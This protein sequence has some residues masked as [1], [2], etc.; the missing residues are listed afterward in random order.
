MSNVIIS[1]GVTSSGLTVVSGES[2]TVNLGGK[3]V[4]T[5]VNNAASS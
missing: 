5:L 4:N 3:I 1:S 2:L